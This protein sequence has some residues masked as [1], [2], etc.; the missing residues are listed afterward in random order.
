MVIRK[1]ARYSAA[2]WLTLVHNGIEYPGT[3]R[4]ISLKGC[5]IQT[6]L[7]AFTG[8]QLRVQIMTP[9]QSEPLRIQRAFVRWRTQDVIGLEFYEVGEAQQS[10]LYRIIQDLEGALYKPSHAIEEPPRLPV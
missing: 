9:D 4:N 5:V 1:H 10:R 6:S 2:W 3:T 7:Q 8:M